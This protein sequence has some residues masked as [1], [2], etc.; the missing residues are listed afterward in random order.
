M[1]FEWD[2]EKNSLNIKNHRISFETASLLATA[3]ER[4]LYYGNLHN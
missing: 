4:S 3:S 2:D 1:V